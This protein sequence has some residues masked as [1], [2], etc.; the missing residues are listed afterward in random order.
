MLDLRDWL[1][2]LES[3]SALRT[4][5]GLHWDL[6]IAVASRRT[7]GER[8]L[9]DEDPRAILF[10]DIVGYPS[11][12]RVFVGSPD[13][14]L[15]A[16]CLGVPESDSPRQ[17]YD[18]IRR[19]IPE[20]E[21][22]LTKFDPKVVKSG[23]I[24]E[25]IDSGKDV[26]LFKF[27][28][29]KWHELDGGRYIGTGDAV[30]TQDPD[31]REINLGAYRIMV[32]D[33][34]TVGLYVSPGHH[35]RLHYENY[36]ARGQACP[37]AISVGQ[38]P[39]ISVIAGTPVPFGQEYN[40]IGAISGEPVEVIREEVTGLPIPAASEIV[41]VGWC[42]PSR[43]RIEGPFGEWTG[44]YASLERPTPIVEVE[45]VYYRNNPIITGSGTPAG[46]FT[47]AILHNHLEKCGI[48]DI[49]AV[50]GLGRLWMVISIK[51][52]YGGHAR[53]AALAASQASPIGAY[54]GR[55]VVVV[56]EDIDPND[57]R[58]VLWAIGT[59]SDPEKDI[60]IV[61]R[62]WSTPLDPTIHKPTKDFSNSR[63]IIDACRPFEWIDE[64][65]KVISWSPE[66]VRKVQ[67][68]VQGK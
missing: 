9:P 40:V 67:E 17:I 5:R 8:N 37:V 1:K 58:Q 30:I 23:P 29:P 12:Y 15:G 10:D 41:I 59:R 11:G 54:H 32:H 63:A 65:P 34:K 24:L 57:M 39:L 64:F 62:L 42:P 47:N 68:K 20:W 49:K 44:Y 19:K 66:L 6:E 50:G 16:L 26:N 7:V 45:R 61:R 35:G 46:G 53:Q 13:P 43:A 18:S 3:R 31:K 36:H 21:A 33:E 60:D 56:D 51:Q 38:H 14:R 25:N 22:S 2:E 4:I 28:A 55:Y 27:P 52:R 48:P